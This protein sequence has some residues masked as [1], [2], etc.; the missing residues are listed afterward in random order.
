V[1][2]DTL[3]A[4]IATLII[5]ILTIASLKLGF[6]LAKEIEGYK[7]ERMVTEIFSTIRNKTSNE[8]TQEIPEKN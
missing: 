6:E 8:K 7:N 1:I 5:M 3:I 2:K 4:F